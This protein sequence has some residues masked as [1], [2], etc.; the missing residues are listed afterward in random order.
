M[1]N[2]FREFFASCFGTIIGIVGLG[3]IIFLIV[4]MSS[5]GSPKT[6]ANSILHLTFSKPI[7]ELTNNNDKS[8]M[9]LDFA[10]IFEEQIGLHDILKLIDIAKEDDNIKGIYLDLK[11]APGGFATMKKI[12]EHI[13]DFKESGK[14]VIAYSNAYSQK[15]YYLA[16]ASEKVY[17]HPMGGMDFMGF[18]AQIMYYKGLMDKLGVKAQIYYAGKFKSATEPFRRTNMSEPNRKQVSEYIGGAYRQYLEVIGESRGISADSLFGIANNARLRNASDVV[19]YGLAD[20]TKYKDEILDE[21]RERVGI[22]EDKDKKL[23]MLTLDK[24]YKIK[25]GDLNK[26]KKGDKVAVV[27]A[28]GSIVDGEGGDGSIGG[29]KYARVIR[30]LRKDDKVK[31][32]VMRVNSGGG[33]ALASEI[34]WRELEMA[35][36]QGIKIVTSMGDVAAS[37]GYYIAAN[38]DSIFAESNTITGSIGVFGMIPNLR[39]LYEDKMGLTMDTVKT[40]R[41]ST[42]SSDMGQ[43]YEFTEEEGQIITESI[44]EIYDIFK[45]RVSEGRSLPPAH[46]D[47]IAQGRVYLGNAAKEIGLVDHLGGL[48]R[49]IS[50]VAGLANLEDYRVVNYPKVKSFEESLMSGLQGENVKIDSELIRQEL[51]QLGLGEDFYEVFKVIQDVKQMKGPQ[52]RLPYEIIIE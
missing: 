47:S 35:K 20:G 33:S 42:M 23:Q 39:G 3:G 27:F 10:K 2:F 5:P 26:I 13:E 44:E 7:P 11:S 15:Q 50:C 31:A 14:F 8:G 38:S 28:E 49:A 17:I 19:K 24:Y 41:F 6:K 43:F 45:T 51:L 1:K 22:K 46:V 29:E 37:G 21:L 32:I 34:I 48:D 18:S 30:K 4:L 12:R 40:A 25:K 36:E 9:S 16:S 52:M